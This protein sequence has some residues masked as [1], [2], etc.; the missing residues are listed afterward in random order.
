MT[1]YRVARGLGSDSIFMYT[2]VCG[3]SNA[4]RRRAS[5]LIMV[6]AAVLVA[7]CGGGG[8]DGGSPNQNPVRVSGRITYDK[9]PFR[10]PGSGLDYANTI[11]SPVRGARVEAIEGNAPPLASTNTNA[12]GEY[13][14]MLPPGRSPFIRVKAQM[15]RAGTPSWN[16]T[17]LNNTGDD[18]LYALDGV[19]FS[20]NT[21][22][23]INLNAPSGWNGARYAS[24]RSAA[25]FS[26]LDAVYD[27][28]NLVLG[29]S[30]NVQ[31]PP[32]AI[33]WSPQNTPADGD[34][35]R[36]EIG[37]TFYLSTDFPPFRAGIYVLGDDDLDTD[38]YDQHVI[39]HEWGHYFQDAFS[40]DDSIGGPHGLDER[41]DL[42]VAFSEGWGNA[43]A[44]MVKADPRYR[45]SFGQGQGVDFDIDVESDGA[46]T[47]GWFSETSVQLVLYDLYDAIPDGVDAVALGFAPIFQ[48]MHGAMRTTEPFTNIFSFIADLKVQNPPFVAGIN[49]LV[50]AQSINATT[51]DAFGSTETNNGGEA[52]NLPIYRSATINGGPQ[53]VCSSI[54]NGDEYNKL[55]QRRF[56]RFNVPGTQQVTFLAAGPAGND[57][58]L[59][60]YGQGFIELSQ[61]DSRPDGVEQF[62][63]TLQPGN[64]I[65]EAY[66]F[67]AV[68]GD[69]A[70]VPQCFNGTISSP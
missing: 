30:P 44:G 69:P 58:D 20:T 2:T 48:T 10:V 66:D 43:F 60:L 13:E 1:R 70:T 63:R 23:V 32:L 39:A 37:T 59:A 38:E 55:G 12:N 18:A 11:Q 4:P 14:F 5:G 36:G 28:Y 40:R 24:T 35:L 7:A 33:R 51:I 29:A 47:P 8:G 52:A 41:L 42:R 64:Y 3:L 62:S 46:S 50:Q 53:P 9:V 17:V 68:D 54:A 6:G 31:L 26:I 25:P 34:P 67:F 21:S 22:Q 19:P 45:D 61:A 15:E 49:A 57:P 16:F 56:L 65:L 27:A